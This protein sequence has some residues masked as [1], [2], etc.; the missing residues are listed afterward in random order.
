MGYA[1]R[2]DADRVAAAATQLSAL[3]DDLE[4]AGGALAQ[5]LR[6][7][8]DAA[9]RGT[10]AVTAEA[11]ARQWQGGMVRVALHG[12]D[13]ARATLEAAELYRTAELLTAR[14]F[15]LPVGGGAP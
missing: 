5:A 7:A 13:L 3:H 2:V 10:L 1:V 4:R 6:A 8:A 15:R 12:R 11:A 9:G 14:A